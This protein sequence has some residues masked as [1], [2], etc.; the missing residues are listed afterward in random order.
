MGGKYD[1]SNKARLLADNPR[2]YS[3][4]ELMVAAAEAQFL[5]K[6]KDDERASHAEHMAG[7][8]EAQQRKRG[9]KRVVTPG[10]VQMICGLLARGESECSACLRAGISLTAWNAAKRSD[11]RLRERIAIARDD[12]ARL[13]HGQRAA[14]LYENQWARSAGRR[15]LKPTPTK[16]ARLV[17]WHLTN[18]VPLN[19]AMIPDA[20]IKNACEQ[21]SMSLDQW[22]RQE[23]A[24]GLLKKIYARRAAIRG[25]QAALPGTGPAQLDWNTTE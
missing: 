3:M 17:M 25:R 6:V 10:R 2:I 24:F 16:Q 8:V 4:C 12:W 5:P 15:A 18:R 7:A 11:A 1:P 20:E 9:R 14:A 13:R 22:R 21:Y 19:F 23:S